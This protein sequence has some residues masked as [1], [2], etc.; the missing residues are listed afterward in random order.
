MRGRTRWG[1]AWVFLG[2]FGVAGLPS[3]SGCSLLGPSFSKPKPVDAYFADPRDTALVR[4]VLVLPFDIEDEGDADPDLVWKT[5]CLELQKTGRFEVLALPEEDRQE[6]LDNLPRLKGVFPLADLLDFCN[7]FG[8]D[9]VIYGTVT[10]F[11]AYKP[12]CLGLRLGMVSAQTGQVI[13]ETDVLYDMADKRSLED[14][15]NYVATVSSPEDSLHK[16]EMTLLSPR[17][18]ASYVCH[19][20]VDRWRVVDAAYR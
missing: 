7:R 14:L 1:W 20:V 8:A 19:R 15:R 12:P 5:F 2:G 4:R 16:W 6:W 13:W 10:R 9:G 3:F 17:R 11:R 18:F